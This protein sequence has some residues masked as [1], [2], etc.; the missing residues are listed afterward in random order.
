MVDKENKKGAA[1][2]EAPTNTQITP[3]TAN[4]CEFH[5][6]CPY[7]IYC[8]VK[9]FP[10]MGFFLLSFVI[11]IADDFVLLNK[12]YYYWVVIYPI[13]CDTVLSQATQI[14]FTEKIPT[15]FIVSMLPKGAL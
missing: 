11:I 10:Y 15:L 9:F 4:V 12:H 5:H 6:L 13:T 3:E 7:Q 1:P 2:R 8:S 14:H